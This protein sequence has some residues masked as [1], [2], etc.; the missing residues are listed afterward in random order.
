[1]ET[2]SLK[3]ENALA[4][5]E[6][7]KNQVNPHFLF[8]SLNIL[9]SIVRKDQEKAERFIE[10][11]SMIYRYILD[12]SNKIVVRVNEEIDFLKAYLDLMKYRHNEGMSYEIEISSDNYN[13]YIIPM[14]LQILVENAFKH[15]NVSKKEPLN[16]RIYVENDM[17]IVENNINKIEK[18]ESREGKGLENLKN[19]ILLI[20]DKKPSFM[21]K[22]DY[23][24]AKIP[25]IEAE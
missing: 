6:A 21:V 7:L 2:E 9:A 18:S 10:K 8:N 1:L 24:V 3:K 15:N 25:I 14:G 5:Y 22:N 17:L 12:T 20:S 16:I 23:F 4:L 11:F 19:R 13:K